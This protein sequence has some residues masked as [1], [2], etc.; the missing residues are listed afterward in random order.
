[1]IKLTADEKAELS[2]RGALGSVSVTRA[3]MLSILHD[4]SNH[5]ATTVHETWARIWRLR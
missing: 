4:L 2:R 1:M 5:S 3:E